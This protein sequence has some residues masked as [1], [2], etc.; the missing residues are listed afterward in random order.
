MSILYCDPEYLIVIRNSSL[1]S[2]V[3]SNVPFVIFHCL[4]FVIYRIVFFIIFS[5][6]SIQ[7]LKDDNFCST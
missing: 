4:F 7:H 2:D 5:I 3:K 1:L 6:F